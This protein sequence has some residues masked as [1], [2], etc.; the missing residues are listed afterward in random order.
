MSVGSLKM[1]EKQFSII[2]FCHNW[3]FSRRK[4]S[5]KKRRSF[6]EISAKKI[7][8]ELIWRR[9]K[10][11][12][13]RE[14]L[15]DL[16]RSTPN[17]VYCQVSGNLTM[18][19]TISIKRKNA[20]NPF[21]K[22]FGTFRPSNNRGLVQT[23]CDLGH[24]PAVSLDTNQRQN[25][26]NVYRKLSLKTSNTK[27]RQKSFKQNITLISENLNSTKIK[28]FNS[29]PNLN[30]ISLEE[31]REQGSEKRSENVFYDDIDNVDD[32]TTNLFLNVI[33]DENDF[34]LISI[35]FDLQ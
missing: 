1:N 16:S 20:E 13:E 10:P 29:C 3:L 24:K 33:P 28:N 15:K 7:L 21:Q 8:E 31:Q 11:R 23:R 12:S 2:G 27:T 6:E 17:L 4:N 32:F 19:P 26:S 35:H 34:D 14:E 5:A 30:Q 9:N 25:Y 22:T 18:K